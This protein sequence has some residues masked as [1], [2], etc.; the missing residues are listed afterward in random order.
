MKRICAWCGK[1]LKER[2]ESLRI[3]ISR[4][5]SQMWKKVKGTAGQEEMVS[6]GICEVCKEKLLQTAEEE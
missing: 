3:Q 6:H 5:F 2:R 4:A 1:E